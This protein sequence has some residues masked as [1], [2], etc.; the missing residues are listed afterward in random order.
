VSGRLLGGRIVVGGWR[1][2]DGVCW[3]IASRV[4]LVARWLG[5]FLATGVPPG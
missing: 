2:L 1:I 5:V 3:L 4:C